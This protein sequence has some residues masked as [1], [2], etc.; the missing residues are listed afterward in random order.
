MCSAIVP[1]PSPLRTTVW[2][3]LQA[4]T[5]RQAAAAITRN[6]RRTLSG[7]PATLLDSV[8]CVNCACARMCARLDL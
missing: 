3:A 2:V 6:T 5:R 7:I 8:G 1:E 4:S